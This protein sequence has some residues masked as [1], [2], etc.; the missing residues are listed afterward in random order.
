MTAA[1][2]HSGDNKTRFASV[3]FG[4]VLNTSGSVLHIFNQQ[5]EAGLHFDDYIHGY[6]AVFLSMSQAVDLCLYASDQMVG[7]DIRSEYGV[8]QHIEFGKSNIRGSDVKYT[9]IGHKSGEKL[10]EE[11][12][13]EK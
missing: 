11:L 10:Y 12:V 3:R 4:N 7:G 13:T 9:I 6:D 5:I 1:N 8:L 2:H